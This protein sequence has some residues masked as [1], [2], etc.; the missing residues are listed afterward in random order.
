M[1]SGLRQYRGHQKVRYSVV[2]YHA[3]KL[4]DYEHSDVL[5][6]SRS[7]E[8]FFLSPAWSLFHWLLVVLSKII[9]RHINAGK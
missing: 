9:F 1:K 8:R 5:W 3:E 2:E 7:A 4:S 6:K